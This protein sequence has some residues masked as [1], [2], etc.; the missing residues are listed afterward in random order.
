MPAP[1]PVRGA[2]TVE[3]PSADDEPGLSSWIQARLAAARSG[4]RERVR[5]PIVYRSAEWGCSCPAAFLGDDPSSHND[6]DTWLSLSYA[7]GV[8]AP[9]VTDDGRVVIAEGHFTGAR[10][11]EDLREGSDDPEE[12]LYTLSVLEVERIVGPAPADRIPR[13]AVLGSE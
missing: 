2:S 9:E 4:R 10:V 7:E 11:R 1:R 6:G 12:Y 13:V 5:V 8:S 3:G